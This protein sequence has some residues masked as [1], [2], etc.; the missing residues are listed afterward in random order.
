MMLANNNQYALRSRDKNKN[1]NE[2]VSVHIQNNALQTSELKRAFTVLPSVSQTN[3]VRQASNTTERVINAEKNIEKSDWPS[4][5]ELEALIRG[6]EEQT[7]TQEEW[8]ELPLQFDKHHEGAAGESTDELIHPLRAEQSMS[9]EKSNYI[10]EQIAYP[11][12]IE[13]NPK[14]D[15][16]KLEYDPTL[17]YSYTN[18]NM[19]PMN[20]EQITVSWGKIASAIVSSIIT[21]VLIGYVLLLA[22]YG[23]QVWP[24]NVISEKLGH[25]EMTLSSSDS[26]EKPLVKS[27]GE[28]A[29]IVEESE[30]ES[31]VLP[32]NSKP[33]EIV[34][35][36]VQTFTYTALQAGVFS[37][38]NTKQAM[39]DNLK[40]QGYPATSL[41]M[42]DGNYVVFA[43]VA[44]SHQATYQTN[45]MSQTELYRKTFSLHVPHLS[46]NE[47]VD[48]TLQQWMF[49][50]Q[51]LV[52]SYMKISEAQFEQTSFSAIYAESY[53]LLQ[54]KSKQVL[55]ETITL[56]ETLSDASLIEKVEWHRLAIEKTNDLIA[57]YQQKP[58]S[59][60]LFAVQQ[61]LLDIIAY[62]SAWFMN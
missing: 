28:P 4:I 25:N 8:L 39:L 51:D 12:S 16:V 32:T 44:S 15:D 38:E 62:E 3:S 58:T 50:Y 56:K 14:I 31:I 40:A 1:D 59:A 45:H 33:V 13:Q 17:R 11:A 42:Y 19:Q 7:Q 21:G 57:Q 6:K 36:P 22:L 53:S 35:Q 2:K 60:S 43:G 49:N 54:E 61:Q 30:G 5:E 9:H 52:T 41:L 47:Q 24:I 29:V 23:V 34:I 55:E 10:T 20:I 37:K 27:E 48:A 26:T 46:D 18:S